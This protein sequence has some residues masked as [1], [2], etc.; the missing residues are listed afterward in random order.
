MAKRA[1]MWSW[2]LE[3]VIMR[4]RSAPCITLHIFYPPSLSP[5][6][7]DPLL[8]GLP[9]AKS[10]TPRGGHTQVCGTQIPVR[11]RHTGPLGAGI[12]YQREYRICR[13][14]INHHKGSDLWT[15]MRRMIESDD[16][17]GRRGGR[18]TESV[19]PIEPAAESH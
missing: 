7:R 1:G 16:Q 6:N 14:R 19:T 12:I 17:G 13:K 8:H 18:S 15:V 5:S 9:I 3:K 11:Q 10:S 4:R 2:S